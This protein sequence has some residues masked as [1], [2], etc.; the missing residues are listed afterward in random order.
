MGLTHSGKQYAMMSKSLVGLIAVP[1]A[2]L[3]PYSK[4]GVS[5]APL[6]ISL[7]ANGQLVWLDGET[8]KHPAGVAGGA[9]SGRR[10]IGLLF[11]ERLPNLLRQIVRFRLNRVPLVL[12]DH[13]AVAALNRDAAGR[14]EG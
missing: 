8:G 1:A 4:V 11:L 14:A 7:F 13:Q 10:L 3:N 5:P 2:T 9:Q 6:W 12:R